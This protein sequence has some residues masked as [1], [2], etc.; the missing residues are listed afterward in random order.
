MGC[1]PIISIISKCVLADEPTSNLDSK[2]DEQIYR[3]M[4]ELNQE[5]HQINQV[6]NNIKVWRPQNAIRG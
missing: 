3:L 6:I 2:T 5:L 1:V 4:L